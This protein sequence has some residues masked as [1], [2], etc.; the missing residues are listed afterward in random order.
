[1][2]ERDEPVLS[3]SM[4]RM[5]PVTREL[6]VRETYTGMTV[7]NTHESLPILL[8]EKDWLSESCDQ[9][10]ARRVH[11]TLRDRARCKDSST[12]S[13]FDPITMESQLLFQRARSGNTRDESSR[14]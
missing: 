4:I 6:I 2:P 7:S 10:T 12:A 14:R 3:L 1:M 5:M 9:D 8:A 11:R 13:L